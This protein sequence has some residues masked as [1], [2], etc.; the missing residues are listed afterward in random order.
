MQGI[1]QVVRKTCENVID[2]GARVVCQVLLPW[3]SLPVASPSSSSSSS[4]TLNPGSGPPLSAPRLP[5]HQ[6]ETLFRESCTREFQNVVGKIKLYLD[7][8]AGGDGTG[9]GG[10]S[11]GT[12][13]VLV[14]RV[15]ERVVEGYREFL[16]AAVGQSQVVKKEEG[17]GEENEFM[18]V[19]V[20]GRM[21]SEAVEE[22]EGGIGH[23]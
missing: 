15:R 9:G 11:M 7:F 10:A 1:D 13:D 22:V 6:T 3:V 4:S 18:G 17:E 20:L 19:G 2:H 12:R 5:P 16:D 8:S 23:S 14:R 21:L